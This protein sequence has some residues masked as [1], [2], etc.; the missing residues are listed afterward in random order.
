[1]AEAFK[2][3]I[4]EQTVG[5]AARHLQRVGPGFDAAR[6]E[7]LALSGLHDLE[8]KARAM[9]LCAALEATLP[10]DFDQAAGLIEAALGPPGPGDDL[11]ALRS[12]PQ[13]LAGWV[14]WPLGEF[15]VRRGAEQPERALRALHALTQ[16]HT[17]E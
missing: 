17:A 13:G 15:V 2:N 7:A 12:G 9:H 1:M 4:N 8:F 6:F 14:V 10:A 11:A 3:L 5:E 16:R